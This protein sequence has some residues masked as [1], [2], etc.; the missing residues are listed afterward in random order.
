MHAFLLKIQIAINFYW[1]SVT[2]T[3]KIKIW[4]M[5]HAFVS[6][7]PRAWC[8]QHYRGLWGCRVNRHI[9]IMSSSEQNN[10]T[11][12]SHCCSALVALLPEL[13]AAVPAELP[14]ASWPRLLFSA[15]WFMCLTFSIFRRWLEQ[16]C[17][18][19]PKWLCSLV[20]MMIFF[21]SWNKHFRP[22]QNIL[23]LL[24]D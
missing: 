2:N 16:F 21:Y 11:K 17:V 12:Q 1:I 10:G 3:K 19:C 23:H 5:W 14:E 7:P 9:F 20:S 13:W 8:C 6:T 18:G 15:C 22:S 24:S 4:N